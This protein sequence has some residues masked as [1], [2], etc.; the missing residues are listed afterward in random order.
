[1]KSAQNKYREES[2]TTL[3]TAVKSRRF[4]PD[5]FAAAHSFGLHG[6][7]GPSLTR[8]RLQYIVRER[9]D[10]GGKRKVYNAYSLSKVRF[11]LT[12]PGAGFSNGR[13]IYSHKASSLTSL[14][15]MTR[16]PRKYRSSLTKRPTA[17]HRSAGVELM[18]R[19]LL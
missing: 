13:H 14:S 15:R 1:M 9:G 12:S 2:A 16:L 11:S 3:R 6:W 8:I 5:G 18:R 7:S 17:C 19:C 4:G 10:D